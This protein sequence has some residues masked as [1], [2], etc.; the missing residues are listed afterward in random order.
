LRIS[1]DILIV[2]LGIAGACLSKMLNDKG[3]DHLVID[4]NDD[5]SASKA[6]AGIINPITGRR[7]VKTWMAD[8]LIPYAVSFYE[9]FG[10]QLNCKL[11]H[12]KRIIR[13]FSSIQEENAWYGRV[14]D[15]AYA[16]YM[17][18]EFDKRAYEKILIPGEGIGEV[19]GYQLDIQNL[20]VK[21]S[22]FLEN[23]G[24]LIRSNFEHDRIV[25]LGDKILYDT[26]ECSKIIFCEGYKVINNPIFNFPPF[27]PAA[28]EV[29]IAKIPDLSPEKLIKR[30]IFIASLPESNLFWIGSTYDWDMSNISKKAGKKEELIKEL[31]KTIDCDFE[32]LDHIMGV[33]PSVNDRRPLLGRHPELSN[34]YLFNGLGTKG[35]SLAPYWANKLCEFI[36]N[37]EPLSAEVDLLRYWS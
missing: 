28:G 13:I 20:I 11:I 21:Y 33:R 32:I 17:V 18:D 36:L 14:D 15:P 22:Q 29:L 30:K 4:S 16:K 1:T 26:I 19:K 2:G 10:K 34:L 27:E 8:Q 24:Q 37:K 12:E 3:V 31:R 5:F 35:S 7:F 9:N 25:R 23:K 6:A